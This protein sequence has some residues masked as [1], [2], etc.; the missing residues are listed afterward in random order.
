MGPQHAIADGPGVDFTVTEAMLPGD[1][2]SE[3]YRVYAGNAYDQDRLVGAGL[4][5]TSFDLAAAGVSSTRFLKIVDDS[6]S[7]PNQPLAGM[8]LDGVTVAFTAQSY[9]TAGTSASGCNAQISASG[10]PSASASS[11]FTLAAATVEGGKDGLF[12]YGTGGRQANTWGNGTSYQCVAPP[13]KRGGL[14]SGVGS[15][16]GCDGSFSQD[17]NARWCPTCPKPNHNPGVGALVQAQLWYRD[18][19]STS[20]QTTSFSDAIE[21][22]IGP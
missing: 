9:C 16:G 2:V 4:G 6:G 14:L 17:L 10:S 15:A 3:T 1:S 7:N 8:D 13:V 21:F 5:T 12:F 11:G 18:P 19:Q 20:N 22:Q